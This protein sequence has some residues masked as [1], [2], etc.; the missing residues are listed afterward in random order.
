M[1][2]RRLALLILGH[3]FPGDDGNIHYP[4]AAG[5]TI[6]RRLLCA[7]PDPSVM[8]SKIACTQVESNF[9]TI[10]I[11]INEIFLSKQQAEDA[12]LVCARQYPQSTVLKR[13][14]IQ[15]DAYIQ[16]GH[17]LLAQEE[18]PR[19]VR[20]PA[21]LG[22]RTL[23]HPD[24]MVQYQSILFILADTPLIRGQQADQR[25]Y[26]RILQ[27]FMQLVAIQ[28]KETHPLDHLVA[29]LI[30]SEFQRNTIDL[31]AAFF[32]PLLLDA[33]ELRNE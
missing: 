16:H 26:T 28:R 15:V 17:N 9:T 20:M 1:V 21:H 33:V 11:I 3:I 25:L 30:L 13:R 18:I 24:V 14:V 10:R 32:Q 27:Q 19:A 12:L 29:I 31:F 5:F 6:Q 23:R 22:E 4:A 7:M 8:Y 2:E